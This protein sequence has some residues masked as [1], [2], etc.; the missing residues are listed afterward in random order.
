MWISFISLYSV[1]GSLFFWYQIQI[2]HHVI[3]STKKNNCILA[4]TFD[5]SVSTETETI[6]YTFALFLES[7][8][9]MKPKKFKENKN[10]FSYRILSS[11]TNITTTRACGLLYSRSIIRSKS[12]GLEWRLTFSDTATQIPNAFAVW[13]ND[14][15]PCFKK[16][17]QFELFS[18]YHDKTLIRNVIQLLL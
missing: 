17:T 14:A 13:I 11:S 9:R 18:N 4:K 10:T 8:I 12:S 7:E 1:S 5:C 15:I 3:V 2:F 6:A 16:Y